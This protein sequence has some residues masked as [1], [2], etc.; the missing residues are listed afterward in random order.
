MELP[1]PILVAAGGVAGATVRWG[2]VETL[3]HAVWSLFIVNTAGAFLLGVIVHSQLQ[4]NLPVR[5]VFGFGFCGALTTF[6]TLTVEVA[7]RLDDGEV[8][9]ALGVG[10]TSLSLGLSFVLLGAST[11]R[12][13]VE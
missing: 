12:L 3:D 4:G 9:A 5:L 2:V 1:K 10:T 11:R 6:S 7:T 8:L 13:V